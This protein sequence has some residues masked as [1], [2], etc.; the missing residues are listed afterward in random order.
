MKSKKQITERGRPVARILGSRQLVKVMGG[1]GTPMPAVT[2]DP[3]TANA[4]VGTPF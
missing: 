3:D 1:D 4:W 2:G